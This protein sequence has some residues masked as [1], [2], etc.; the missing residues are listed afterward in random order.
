MRPRLR[1]RLLRVPPQHPRG[2][3]CDLRFQIGAPGVGA[4]SWS[5]SARELGEALL[6]QA[7]HWASLLATHG[8]SPTAARTATSIRSSM[9][10]QEARYMR[11]FG[12]RR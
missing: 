5:S 4:T 11:L 3:R 8:G 9:G 12:V 7:G 10:A 6:F 1:H 2:D